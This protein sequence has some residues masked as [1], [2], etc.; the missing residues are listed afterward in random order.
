MYLPRYSTP[1]ATHESVLL[2]ILLLGA[3]GSLTDVISNITVPLTVLNYGP[4]PLPTNAEA[5]L[6]AMEAGML[7]Y[8]NI[9]FLFC[10]FY[11]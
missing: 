8:Y 10:M 9:S 5:A 4:Y 6:Q 3:A 7:L 2:H 1:S 11:C